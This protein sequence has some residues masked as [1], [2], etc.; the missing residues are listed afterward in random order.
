MKEAQNKSPAELFAANLS[1]LRKRYPDLAPAVE[2]FPERR[3]V[4]CFKARDGGMAYGLRQ[5]NGQ[6]APLTDPIA[7]LARLQQ[8]LDQFNAQLHD[9]TRP[10]LIVGLYPGI[11]LSG[12]FNLSESCALPHCPQPIWVC[13]DS[14]AC[15]YGCLSA[16]DMREIIASERVRFF[17]H[18]TSRSA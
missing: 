10:V 8:Q 14:L 6:I 18:A 17:W 4:C 7:P 12:I 3:Q 1:L 11:E 15:F 2:N 9:F 5:N 16:W 13:L